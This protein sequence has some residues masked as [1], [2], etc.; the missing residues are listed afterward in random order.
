M[1]INICGIPHEIIER[2]DVFD[3]TELHFGQID[4][5]QCKI[6]IAKESTS[7]VKAETLCHEILHGMLVH[8]GYR[9]LSN[10]ETFVQALGNAISQTFKVKAVTE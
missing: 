9:E 6:Y 7:E 3:A 1:I 5:K 2:E 4:F 10:D 8:L